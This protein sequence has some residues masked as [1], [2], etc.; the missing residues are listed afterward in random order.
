M[1][2][3]SDKDRDHPAEA[4]PRRPLRWWP[5]A[6][7][8]V[9]A[10]G[11]VVWVWQSYGRQRQ[12]R[13]IA[14]AI[15]GLITLFLLLLWCLFLSRL[16]WRIRLGVFGGV[17]GLI[18]LVMALFRFHGVTGDLVPVFQWRWERPSWTS[19]AE[20]TNPIVEHRPGATDSIHQRLASIPWPASQQHGRAAGIGARL[21]GAGAPTPLAP[22]GR[23]WM[24]RVRGSRQPRHHPGTT[25]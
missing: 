3:S 18:L 12:D 6:V 19:L 7:I 11:A 17:V 23:S 8:L 24:V 22:A 16:R 2:D 15:I 9:L 13:N 20:R 10:A 25:R 5:V 1:T 21:E 4:A 14:T